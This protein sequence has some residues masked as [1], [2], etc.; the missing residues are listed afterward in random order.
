MG[1]AMISMYMVVVWVVLQSGWL[2]GSA[3]TVAY[4]PT[5]VKE[6]WTSLLTG[7]LE[8]KATGMAKRTGNGC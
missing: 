1:W 4:D 7:A 5:G 8:V 3:A 6:V 2:H